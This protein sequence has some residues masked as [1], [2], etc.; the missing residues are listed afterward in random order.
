MAGLKKSFL[1]GLMFLIASNVIVMANDE[2]N[3]SKFFA[4]FAGAKKLPMR[5]VEPITYEEAQKALS[6]IEATYDEDGRLIR[7]TKFVN[8]TIYFVQSTSYDNEGKIARVI[9]KD[10]EGNITEENK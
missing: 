8:K 1:A 6:Y 10:A 3:N 2:G 5:P 7:L 9:V 4:S